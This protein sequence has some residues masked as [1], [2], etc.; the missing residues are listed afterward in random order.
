M[1][2]KTFTFNLS[3]SISEETL[4]KSGLKF[5]I[6]GGASP[7]SNLDISVSNAS[8]LN[9]PIAL[10]VPY[11]IE[12]IFPISYTVVIKLSHPT[13]VN[14]DDLNIRY[15]EDSWKEYTRD[16]IVNMQRK[17]APLHNF[18]D[19]EGNPQND[20]NYNSPFITTGLNLQYNSVIDTTLQFSYD[21]SVNIIFTDDANPVRLINSRWILL[22]GGQ[23]ASIGERR[24]IKDT[25]TYSN[26][27]FHRTE[28]I[29]SY[30]NSVDVE[31][32]GLQN[33]G[34]LAYGGYRYFFRY[35]TADGAETNIIEET[36]LIEVHKGDTVLTAKGG[37]LDGN[38]EQAVSLILSNLDNSYYAIRLYYTVASGQVGSISLAYKVAQLYV[39]EDSKCTILHTGFEKVESINKDILNVNYSLISTAKTLAV[40]NNRLLLSNVEIT[41]LYNVRLSNAAASVKIDESNFEIKHPVSML[42]DSDEN[43]SN[44]KFTYDKLGYWRGETYELGLVYTSDDGL[45]PVYP[46]RGMDNLNGDA[47]YDPLLVGNTGPG[48]FENGENSLGVYRTDKSMVGFWTQYSEDIVF[49]GVRLRADVSKLLG[50]KDTQTSYEILC[51]SGIYIVHDSADDSYYLNGTFTKGWDASTL[52]HVW[53]GMPTPTMEI[54]FIFTNI[55]GTEGRCI[56]EA[57][58]VNFVM[59]TDIVGGTYLDNQTG[60]MPQLPGNYTGFF[61]VRRI[62]KQDKVAQGVLTPS[63]AIPTTASIDPKTL[64]AIQGNWTGIG[65]ESDTYG[66]NVTYVPA[67]ACCTPWGVETMEKVQYQIGAHTDPLPPPENKHVDFIQRAPIMTYDKQAAWS[68]YSADVDTAHVSFA[69]KY[70]G[71]K[72]GISVYIEG[73]PSTFNMVKDP[74]LLNIALPDRVNLQDKYGTSGTVVRKYIAETNYTE[75]GSF[76]PSIEGFSAKHDRNLCLYTNEKITHYNS[77]NFSYYNGGTIPFINGPLTVGVDGDDAGDDDESGQ[78]LDSNVL[79]NRTPSVMVNYGRYLGIKIKDYTEG[80]EDLNMETISNGDPIRNENW[81]SSL[82]T[83]YVDDNWKRRP[84]QDDDTPYGMLANIYDGERSGE[85]SRDAWESRY[86][87]DED[88]AYYAITKRYS[89]NDFSFETSSADLYGGDCYLGTQWKQVWG[90]T[91]IPGAITSN[92][93]D[94]YR[95]D[96]SALGLLEYGFAIPIPAQANNNFNIREEERADE[97]EY[98]IYGRDRSFL[99]GKTKIRGDRLLETGNYNKGYTNSYSDKAHVRL[100]VNTPFI[101]VSYPNRIYNSGV[102]DDT[103]LWNGFTVFN[104]LNF[105][106]YNSELGAVTKIV[107]VNNYTYIIFHH[108]IAQVGVNERSMISADT[109]GIFTESYD[110]LSSKSN[111]VSAD[112]GSQHLHSIVGSAN[113]LYGVDVINKKIWRT[114]QKGAAIISDFKVQSLVTSI[115]DAMQGY[116]SDIDGTFDVYSTYDL[117]KGEIFFT[118]FVRNTVDTEY[119]YARTLVFNEILG[120]WI[121]ETDDTRKFFFK[122]GDDRYSMQSLTKQHIEASELGLIYKYYRD[123]TNTRKSYFNKFYGKVYNAS[124]GFNVM[125]NPLESKIFE[126]IYIVGNGAIPY[127]GVYTLE[128]LVG[129][130]PQTFIPSTNVSY[131]VPTYTVSGVSGD[132]WFELTPATNIIKWNGESLG[133]GDF[134]SISDDFGTVHYFVCTGVEVLAITKIYVDK[135]LGSDFTA[136][137]VTMGYRNPVRLATA[138]YEDKHTKL[139]LNA[140]DTI[141]KFKLTIPRGKWM[142]TT[143]VYDGM[144]PMYIDKILSSY[145]TSYS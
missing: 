45:S 15:I 78:K 50:F 25:N 124:L 86:K 98:M 119:M 29:P 69:S 35:I 16:E 83:K 14:I 49:K 38:S 72:F 120:I 90:P 19:D 117:L 141:S 40:A 33:G 133:T 140:A 114:G 56:I 64:T 81:Q 23:K 135:I 77:L 102:A 88:S 139:R 100:N 137:P 131:T 11:I 136:Q 6:Y 37:D 113:F 79:E 8:M 96:R 44:P 65:V 76:N 43:Y 41:D 57:G 20:I 99:P 70:N 21:G 116:V 97:L 122:S 46:V 18:Y 80:L 101:K 132:D 89:L 61:F 105:K 143:L 51:E 3:T 111:V 112:F 55:D 87:G 91:G 7:H 109:G 26:E 84:I 144:A 9:E 71:G 74:P 104:G 59:T 62:R 126:N 108:G 129:D 138:I 36:R 107:T 5:E 32:N 145:T 68:F 118:F 130:R 110:V 95:F 22:E 47:S 85:I 115:I 2:S 27:N 34:N 58:T 17:Y 13:S 75:S 52:C 93:L 128:D 54:E 134:I 142:G 66:R 48:F 24:Q 10:T 121:T 67:P 39:I 63:A 1:Q 123:E 60:L 42:D 53:G 12:L 73:I 82:L 4:Q 127:K 94:L 30:K 92:E 103:Q 28:L 125:D 106:D 31:F